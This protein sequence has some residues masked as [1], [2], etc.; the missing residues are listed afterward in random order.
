MKEKWL[1]VRRNASSN[2]SFHEERGKT[3]K[4]DRPETRVSSEIGEVE[5]KKSAGADGM[6]DLDHFF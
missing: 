1:K 3:Q 2:E 4:V 5:Q 6:V